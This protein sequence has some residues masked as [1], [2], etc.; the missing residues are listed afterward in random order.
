MVAGMD[1]QS[2]RAYQVIFEE[3]ADGRRRARVQTFRLGYDTDGEV[4][5]IPE[6]L[7]VNGDGELTAQTISYGSLDGTSGSAVSSTDDVVPTSLSGDEPFT[8]PVPAAVFP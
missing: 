8:Y 7:Y 3:N 5:I 1:N 2:E 6:H 4:F